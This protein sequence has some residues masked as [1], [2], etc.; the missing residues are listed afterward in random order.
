MRGVI[1]VALLVLSPAI[2]A[3]TGLAATIQFQATGSM[4]EPR[5]IHTATT[6]N[7]GRVLIAGGFTN[8]GGV[9]S[10][11]IEI[12]EPTTGTFTSAT[13]VFDLDRVTTTTLLADGRVLFAAESR[14][15]IYAPATGTLTPAGNL[16]APHAGYTA[17]RL[18]DGRV[19]FVGG[20][21]PAAPGEPTTTSTTGGGTDG[22]VITA[23]AQLYDPVTGTSHE[24]ARM[25]VARSAHTATLLLTG[26][27]LVAGGSNRFGTNLTAELYDPIAGSFAPTGGLVGASSTNT[28]VRLLSGDV[29]LISSDSS[30]QLYDAASGTFSAVGSMALSRFGFTANLLPNGSV[31]VAGGTGSDGR[32]L[33]SAELYVPS[34][35]GFVSAGTMTSERTTQAA[36]LLS[37]GRVL[38]SGGIS[39][40]HGTS[41]TGSTTGSTGG[42]GSSTSATTTGATG[43]TGTSTGGTGTGGTT[44]GG[45]GT[46]GTSTG[47]TTTGGGAVPTQTMTTTVS[48]EPM[49]ESSAELYVPEVDSTPPTMTC[50]VTPKTIWPPDQRLVAITASV[51]VDDPGSGP[52]GFQLVSVSA[53]EAIGTGDIVGFATDTADLE[54]TVRADRQS[55]DG[56][57][58]TWTYRGF[59]V[60][61][62]TA[63]CTATVL[64]PHDQRPDETR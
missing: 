53:S 1:V 6:L 44:T 42:G 64:V 60:A 12:Y 14:A 51:Q 45:T 49:I 33:A 22:T 31:L 43:T 59:D 39:N 5:F 15:E 25:A 7:D 52:A 9:W 50:D 11:K 38:I 61:G 46:T 48:T 56:R 20:V 8:L 21:G 63:T 55:K 41:G 30:A 29:L 2:A 3:A 57:T 13:A 24:T 28:A 36:A 4:S 18:V 23:F 37:D 34:H 35:R 32:S 26:K 16:I 54:G 62:N 47:G 10:R 27:V 58:Y 19:L 40:L 17:T